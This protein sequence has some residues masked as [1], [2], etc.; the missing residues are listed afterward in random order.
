MQTRLMLLLLPGMCH[1]YDN[2]GKNIENV[3]SQEVV[4][5]FFIKM[6]HIK[7][8]FDEHRYVE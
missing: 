1:K 6:D 4:I 3:L 7:V 8:S 5:R 2:E